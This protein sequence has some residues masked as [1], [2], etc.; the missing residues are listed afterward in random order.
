MHFCIHCLT[1]IFIANLI[2]S[3]PNPCSLLGLYNI[4]RTGTAKLWIQQCICLGEKF[5]KCKQTQ[6]A[7]AT[8][9]PCTS[10]YRHPSL[11]LCDFNNYCKHITNESRKS[12]HMNGF[13]VWEWVSFY[14]FAYISL[15]HNTERHK[16]KFAD[17]LTLLSRVQ[18]TIREKKA[19]STDWDQSKI[20]SFWNIQNS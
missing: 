12:K 18:C 14:Y 10:A 4:L 16:L 8:K 19:Q 20:Y 7:K 17:V 9:C 3:P 11:L 6:N 15:K 1:L 2:P 13:L 5:S